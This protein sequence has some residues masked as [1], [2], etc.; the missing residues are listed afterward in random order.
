MF[1]KCL[2]ASFVFHII[3]IIGAGF[4]SPHSPMQ[5]KP[6]VF[7]LMAAAGDNSAGTAESVG[8]LQFVS[9]T[10][11]ENVPYPQNVSDRIAKPLQSGFYQLPQLQPKDRAADNP[12]GGTREAVVYDSGEGKTDQNDL[13]TPSTSMRG[14]VSFNG[15]PSPGENLGLDGNGFDKGIQGGVGGRK[16]EGDKITPVAT[17]QPRS[18]PLEAQNKGW[19]G[20]VKVEAALNRKGHIESVKL[21]QSSGYKI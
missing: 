14:T 9:K 18:Y 5:P 8:E 16:Q 17:Y 19:E 10:K 4:T 1:K 6:A 20:I 11:S 3:F 7:Q 12:E 15:S 13:N 21:L 2:L